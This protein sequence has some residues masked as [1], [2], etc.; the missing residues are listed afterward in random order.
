MGLLKLQAAPTLQDD[1]ESDEKSD[2]HSDINQDG[3]EQEQRLVI[4]SRDEDDYDDN[5]G[6]MDLNKVI[7]Y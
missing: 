2:Y 5:D 1:D 6:E 7:E 3:Q 4:S